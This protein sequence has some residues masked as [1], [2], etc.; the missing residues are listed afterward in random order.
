MRLSRIL[1]CQQ[2][3]FPLLL[4]LTLIIMANPARSQQT[5]SAASQP[6]APSNKPS[7]PPGIDPKTRT[8]LYETIQEDWSSLQI[9]TS[10][11]RPERP[12]LGQVD[13]EEKFTRTLVQMKWRPGD[14]IDLW[15][16]IPKGVKNPPA[17]LYLYNM[18]EDTDRFRDNS[19]CER[20]TSG[21]LAAVGFVSALSGPR[22][23][24][25]PLKQW[26]VSELQES[27]GSTVHDVKF[28]LDY[29]AYRGDIDMNRIGMFGTGSGG[30]IAILT[31]AGDPR[32]K[33]VDALD[34]WGDWS[35][36]LAE[37]PIV[38]DDPDRAN[39]VTSDFLKKVAPLDPVKWLPELKIPIRIQQVHDNDATPIDCKD[40]IRAAAPKQAEIV[41]FAAMNDLALR[42]GGGRLFQ[43]VKNGLQPPTGKP[44]QT[45]APG[46]SVAAAKVPAS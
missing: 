11:L 34:P 28:I 16:V 27:L 35:H 23:H 44:G 25:R 38:R 36:F 18:T 14:P 31:A 9:G 19:W 24:D 29:L 45:T 4:S 2:N 10:N 17:V 1:N 46:G 42:E 26:F 40:R 30:T 15:I 6:E 7:M 8:P 32:I 43:W 39:Y 22:F 33:V 21:G 41:R 20:A 13:D 5:S 37:S 12:L 3:F